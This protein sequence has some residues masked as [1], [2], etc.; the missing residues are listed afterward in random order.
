M[1]MS[2]THLGVKLAGFVLALGAALGAGAALGSAA[3]PIDVDDR[4]EHEVEHT[5]TPTTAAQPESHW[6]G[7]TDGH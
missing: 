7:H 6:G 4:G 3:G 5:P 1:D 2:R